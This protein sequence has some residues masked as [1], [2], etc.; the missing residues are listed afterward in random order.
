MRPPVDCARMY[1]CA[2]VCCVFLHLPPFVSDV[3]THPVFLFPPLFITCS[4]SQT[5]LYP[6]FFLLLFRRCSAIEPLPHL[7]PCLCLHFAFFL[8]S[9]LLLSSIFVSVRYYSSFAG[10]LFSCFFDSASFFRLSSPCYLTLVRTEC[11]SDLLHLSLPS[12]PPPL[13]VLTSSVDSANTCHCSPLL[14][15]T[16]FLQMSLPLLVLHVVRSSSRCSCFA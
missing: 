5:I 14:L 15:L 13:S 4:Y 6:I 1:P 7:S 12:S 8:L 2:S 11:F 16:S 9:I 10:P 3:D